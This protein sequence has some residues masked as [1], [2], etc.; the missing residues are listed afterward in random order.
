MDDIFKVKTAEKIFNESFKSLN[1]FEF[2]FLE[3]IIEYN[4]RNYFL[5]LTEKQEH[6][7][8]KIYNKYKK[9][10]VKDDSVAD[11]I[12][13]IMRGVELSDIDKDFIKTYSNVFCENENVK[14]IIEMFRIKKDI[15]LKK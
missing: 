14:K 12:F 8:L 5:E 10:I 11:K 9:E 3:S 7:Y 15:K 4:S 13:K 1:D 6:V 2:R